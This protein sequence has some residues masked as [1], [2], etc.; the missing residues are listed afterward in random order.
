MKAVRI[1]KNRN[2]N[3][4][5]TAN[6]IRMPIALQES[7]IRFVKYPCQLSKF[8][9]RPNFIVSYLFPSFSIY[10]YMLMSAFITMLLYCCYVSLILNISNLHNY[11]KCLVLSMNQYQSTK[12]F[13]SYL[14]ISYLIRPSHIISSSSG[15]LKCIVN[16]IDNLYT[17]IHIKTI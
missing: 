2:R 13:L 15:Q 17:R 9:F 5:I 1:G 6:L 10:I 3:L 14:L 4:A 11:I 7:S 8:T 16:S 12:M